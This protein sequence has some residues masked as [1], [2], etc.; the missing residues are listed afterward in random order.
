MN[1]LLFRIRRLSST[2]AIVLLTLFTLLLTWQVRNYSQSL[3]IQNIHSQGE[4]R[5]LGYITGIRQTLNRSNH[6]PYVLSQNSDVRGLLAGNQGLQQQVNQYLEQTNQIVSSARW[7]VLNTGG[8]VVASSSWRGASSELGRYYG[9]RPFFF[10]AREGELGHYVQLPGVI[11]VPGFYL[12]APVYDELELIGVAVVMIDL[13]KLQEIW[14]VA[15]E[16]LLVSD[17]EGLIFLSSLPEWRDHRL[18]GFGYLESVQLLP[19]Q[20]QQLELTDGTNVSILSEGEEQRYLVQSV[21]LDDLKWQVHILSDLAPVRQQQKTVTLFCLGAGFVIALL[22][23][24]FRE[25]LLRNISRRETETLRLHNEAQQRAIINNT[26]SGLLMMDSHG[27]VMFIN[28]RALQQFGSEE[29]SV[30]GQ[31]IDN[32]IDIENS[33]TELNELFDGLSHGERVE[34]INIVEGN[35]S[36][37]DGSSFPMLISVNPIAWEDRDGYLVTLIDITL[38]KRAEQAL[39]RANEELEQR[40]TERT[41]ELR[42]AQGELIQSSKLAALGTMSAAIAHELNQ[43]LTA[44]RTTASSSKILLQ[45]QQYDAVE[46]NL[47]RLGEMT[48]RMALITSQLKIF[49]HK[50][51]EKFGAVDFGMVISHVLQMF[52]ERFEEDEVTVSQ[53][54]PENICVRGDQPRLEQVLINL[55]R[56]ALDSMSASS[57]RTLHVELYKDLDQACLTIRDSGCGISDEVHAHLFDPFFTTKDVGEGLGLGL[58]ISYGIIRDLE[59][60]IRVENIATG[61]ACF[62]VWIP[63]NSSPE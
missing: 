14:A 53:Q 34:P 22:A 37:M 63:L 54:L 7:F 56:N 38:R 45:R 31:R 21:G 18:P 13:R 55:V 59:G 26:Q 40:V 5:L 8:Y 32:F 44:I 17:Q 41:E 25:R 2:S 16:R 58:S 12:S 43:P 62:K 3:A 19:Y 42:E 35:A 49:A 60:G 20:W 48:E 29:S 1:S 30:L 4:D 61:G 33:P 27:L 50:R 46:Q 28:P 36:R 10:K 15:Q 23:L 52:V 51:P 9:D 57:V 6:L 24:F 39:K 47:D 11:D